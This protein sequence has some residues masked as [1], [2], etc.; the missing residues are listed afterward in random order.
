MA[1]AINEYTDG[2]IESVVYAYENDMLDI[3]QV[4]DMLDY[5][6]VDWNEFVAKLTVSE[7][8]IEAC[9]FMQ[10]NGHK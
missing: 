5:I 7:K 9:Q 10:E 8:T 2:Q 3:Y 6:C 1:Y 4:E